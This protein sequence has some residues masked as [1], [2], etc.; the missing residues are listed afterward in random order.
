MTPAMMTMSPD[1]P[2]I[3]SAN[4]NNGSHISWSKTQNIMENTQLRLDI[5]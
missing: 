1:H 5:A 3:S 2:K 4:N